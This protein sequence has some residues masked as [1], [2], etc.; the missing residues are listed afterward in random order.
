M[1]VTMTTDV[2]FATKCVTASHGMQA[3]AV[4]VAYLALIL[5]LNALF[6]STHANAKRIPICRQRQLNAFRWWGFFWL[7]IRHKYTDASSMTLDSRGRHVAVCLRLFFYQSF[8]ILSINKCVFAFLK[9]K[10]QISLK[11]WTHV[12]KNLLHNHLLWQNHSQDLLTE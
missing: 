5:P 8:F 10:W 6:W 2:L 3:W 1:S 12:W 7:P 11:T 4:F 9:C